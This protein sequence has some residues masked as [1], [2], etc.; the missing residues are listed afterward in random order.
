MTSAPPQ[1]S[2]SFESRRRIRDRGNVASRH[3]ISNQTL[4]PG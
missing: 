1:S 4:A 2:W 3:L